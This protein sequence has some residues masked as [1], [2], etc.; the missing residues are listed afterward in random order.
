MMGEI[1]PFT[2]EK[3]DFLMD[4][5]KQNEENEKLFWKTQIGRSNNN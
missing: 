3:L 5:Y 2:Q 1:E 4:Q